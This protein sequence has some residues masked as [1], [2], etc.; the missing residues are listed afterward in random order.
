MSTMSTFPGY[1]QRQRVTVTD[2][3]C[4]GCYEDPRRW[5]PHWEGAMCRPRNRMV[6]VEAHILAPVTLVIHREAPQEAPPTD[7]ATR[8]MEMVD[9][10][11]RDDMRAVFA[12]LAMLI[13]RH[14]DNQ[15]A[16]AI[17]NQVKV[18]SECRREATLP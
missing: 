13:D 3:T 15:V 2:E 14:Q 1:C 9:S 12:N 6:C 18:H 10:L 4:L 8:F 7:N 5:Y 11:S 16:G 17:Y